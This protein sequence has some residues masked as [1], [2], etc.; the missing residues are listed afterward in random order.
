MRKSS[1]PIKLGFSSNRHSVH[2][3]IYPDW[4]SSEFACLS[5]KLTGAG[6][7]QT[8]LL[9]PIKGDKNYIYLKPNKIWLSC[10]KTNYD[11][12]VFLKNYYEDSKTYLSEYDMEILIF[13]DMSEYRK[14]AVALELTK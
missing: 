12:K 4:N 7:I 2:S 13:D 6:D 9:V 10:K 14:Y 1:V 8:N 11:V 5:F 3:I